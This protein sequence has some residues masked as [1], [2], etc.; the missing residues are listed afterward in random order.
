MNSVKY[1]GKT[2]DL[3]AARALMDDEICEVLH[4][5]VDTEQQFMEEYAKAHEEKYGVEFV[6]S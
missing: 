3:D 4:G 6:F 1:N 2:I 5:M